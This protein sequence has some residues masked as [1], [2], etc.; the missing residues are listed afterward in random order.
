MM[1]RIV[2]ILI[3]ALH[4]NQ[5]GYERIYSSQNINFEISEILIEGD[6]KIGRQIK[7]RLNSLMNVDGAVKSYKIIINSDFTKNISS[8]DKQ[9]NPK[10]FLLNV[11]VKLTHI[12]DDNIEVDMI[13]AENINYNNNDDK[14]NLRRYEDSLRENLTEKI[15]E[16]ILI[17]LQSLPANVKSN[18]SL[19]G[20]IGYTYKSNTNDN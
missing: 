19:T 9:G 6:I 8:K 10:T 20:N 15:V 13:F 3:F 5:C 12:K 7:R 14:F 4:L 1:F 18:T 11:N 16:N 17:Y 2:I